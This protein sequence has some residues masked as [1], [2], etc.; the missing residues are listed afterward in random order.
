[1]PQVY[2]RLSRQQGPGT[3]D[4]G[5]IVRRREAAKRASAARESKVTL[6]RAYRKGELP[7]IDSLSLASF[8]EPLGAPRARCVRTAACLDLS[9]PEALLRHMHVSALMQTRKV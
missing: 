4:V 3:T 2:R 9:R 8:L 5:R 6:L 7:D 1:M